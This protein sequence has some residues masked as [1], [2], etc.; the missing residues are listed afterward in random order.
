MPEATEIKGDVRSALIQLIRDL[1][2]GEQSNTQ[3]LNRWDILRGN[4]W[5]TE[6]KLEVQHRNKYA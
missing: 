6:T 4:D 5:F 1:T 2:Q 3:M